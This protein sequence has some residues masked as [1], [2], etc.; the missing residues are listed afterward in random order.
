M[1]VDAAQRLQLRCVGKL[2]GVG[3]GRG[4]S[5]LVV[6]SGLPVPG[7]ASMA[8]L[9]AVLAPEPSTTHGSHAHLCQHPV[10]GAVVPASKDEDTRLTTGAQ[11]AVLCVRRGDHYDA[12]RC[13]SRVIII[14]CCCCH[15][16]RAS[17]LQLHIALA[18]LRQHTARATARCLGQRSCRAQ[19]YQ[20][21]H[22]TNN[23]M[24]VHVQCN[25][26]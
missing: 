16:I 23:T 7:S 21:L 5:N 8:A 22:T 13:T 3:G 4:L 11:R 17:D 19:C 6:H 24:S 2:R 15:L 1:P 14:T 18:C 26:G 9:A 25:H 10:L 20:Q 12:G